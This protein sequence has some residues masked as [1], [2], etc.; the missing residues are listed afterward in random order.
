MHK[1]LWNKDFVLMLQGDAVSSLGDIL[2][3]VAI[4]YWVYEKTGSST[5]MGLM[6]SISM[7]MTMIVMPFSGTII[8][9][10][11][12]KAVIVGMDV[13]R[14]IIMLA[15]G[16]LA[17]ADSLSVAAVLIAAFLA[18][19][20]AVFFEP[21]VGTL[22][23]DVIPHDDMVRGQSIQNGVNTFLGLVGKAFSGAVVV[24]LGVPLVIV[25]NGV[26]YLISAV[27]ELFITVPKTKAQ[28][29]NVTAKS[30]FCDFG[31]AIRE[32]IRNKYLRLFI[33]SVLILNLLGAGPYT[34]MLPFVLEK[35]FTVD[36]YGYLMSIETAASFACVVMLGVIK[37]GNR[38]RYRFF[39]WGFLGQ[40]FLL[41]IAYLTGNFAVMAV[42][43]F[44]GSF[45][46]MLG[47][48]VF[49]ASLVL[50]LP[51][52]KRGALLG[53]LSAAS[54]GG[55]ALSAVIYGVLCDTFPIPIVFVAGNLLSLPLMAYL[56]FHRDTKDFVLTH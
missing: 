3:S 13:A 36:M 32:I 47:N 19:M 42:F 21:A 9:K 37:F 44:L 34:L 31:V 55:V 53:F 43:L 17:F 39:V 20:C 12:R 5:L 28:G 48:G 25:L 6:S 11:N 23:L 35:G 14:G 46:N 52:D 38:T 24:F 10:C 30:L 4:G 22:Y 56:C 27:T 16:L 15:I 8:D 33:P 29:Q 1:K 7:F 26:S 45:A 18:S 2:Y 51:E 54:T 41:S 40:I 50:A 49:N